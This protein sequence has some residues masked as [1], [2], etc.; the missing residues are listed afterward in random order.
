MENS[1]RQYSLERAIHDFL[2]ERCGAAYKIKGISTVQL[3][4]L[5]LGTSGISTTKLK[6]IL[7]LNGI[8][9]KLILEVDGNSVTIIL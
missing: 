5:K 7:A 6:E 2:V 3:S 8:T 9:G 1:K 4:K